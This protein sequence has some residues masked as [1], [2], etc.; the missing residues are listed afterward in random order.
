MKTVKI[1]DDV[2]EKL[3]KLAEKRNI[4]L[5]DLIT[6]ILNVYLG[7]SSEERPIKNIIDKVIV[8]TREDKCHRCGRTIKVGEQFRYVKYIYEDAPPKVYK[9]CID[10]YLQ[11]SALGKYYLEKRKLEITI[12]EL[13]KMADELVERIE[14]LKLSA[15]IFNIKN[16]IINLLRSIKHPL[17]SFNAKK[18]DVQAV[19]EKL[20]KLDELVSRVEKLESMV[21]SSPFVRR[22]IVREEA[23]RS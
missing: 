3:S 12:R 5:N 2:H 1:S 15:E 18:E 13:K 20:E 23:V 17:L 16:E 4:S 22:K 19:L 9:E 11:T 8:A 10:C 14:R 6:E 21:M 7:G